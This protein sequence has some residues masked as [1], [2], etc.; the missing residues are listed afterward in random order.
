M[1]LIRFF[2]AASVVISHNGIVAPGI[3]GHLAVMAFF[4]I[5]GFY[6]ALVLNEKYQGNI[7]GFYTSRILRLWPS[8]IVVYAAVLLFISPMGSQIYYNAFTAFYVWFTSITMLFYQT[9]GWFGFNAEGH[10]VFLNTNELNDTLPLLI[11]ATHMQQMWSVGVEICFYIIAPLFAR[12][13]KWIIILYVISLIAYLGIKKFLFFHHPFDHRSA[14]CS[15][16]LFLSGNI[17]Y[18]AWAKLRDLNRLPTLNSI[19][20]SVAGIFITIALIEIAWR[21]FYTNPYMIILCYTIFA[22]LI[23]LLFSATKDSKLD[24]LVGELS[25][26]IYLT[27]W[28]IVAFLI[29]DHR[30][31]WLWSFVIILISV[32]C[33]LVLH[34]VIDRNVERYRRK[35]VVH[36]TST[37]SA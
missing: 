16:W 17:S 7:K 36:K 32:G 27:H 25:Y 9:L 11:D 24:R 28:P 21:N 18:F 6:M 3:A 5:S 4:V 34:F 23:I 33:S 15:F 26:P 35:L 20:I 12:K 14:I 1:G 19:F 31:S 37:T 2:L 22:V 8:Y 30:G 29:T 10:L 13:L